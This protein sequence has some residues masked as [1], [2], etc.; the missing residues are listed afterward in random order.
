LVGACRRK[1]IGT[2]RRDRDARPAPDL[3]ERRFSAD[4]PNK[5]WVADIAYIPTAAS[6]SFLAVVL[7]A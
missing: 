1:W 3:V 6:F 4:G 5:L 7:D 2:T